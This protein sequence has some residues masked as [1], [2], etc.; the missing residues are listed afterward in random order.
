MM[1]LS[2]ADMRFEVLF[3]KFSCAEPFVADFDGAMKRP[4]AR[5]YRVNAKSI[6]VLRRHCV[7]RNRP[8]SSK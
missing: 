8:H 5:R 3:L 4:R 7:E 1:A 2:T 6:P